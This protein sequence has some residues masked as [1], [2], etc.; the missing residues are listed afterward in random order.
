MESMSNYSSFLIILSGLSWIA[1][2]AEAARV[3]L[4][5]KSYA[6]PV[7]AIGLNLSWAVMHTLLVGQV[8]G[9][10]LPVFIVAVRLELDIVILYTWFKF[11]AK[12]FPSNPGEAWFIPWSLLVI[13]VSFILHSAFILEFG[14]E[15]GLAY[16]AVMQN[17][18]MSMLFIAMLSRRKSKRSQSMIIG[19]AKLTASLSTTIFYG[20][21]EV[22]AS[23]GPNY[24]L[25]VI[26]FL[27]CLFDLIYI[28]LLSQAKPY[29]KKEHSTSVVKRNVTGGEFDAFRV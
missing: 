21:V 4:R 17:L 27:S 28:A 16:T 1:I 24:L 8:D 7:W 23:H 25:L 3:G 22:E 14:T 10:T 6:I 26:G 9:P 13:A 20:I 19:M 5:D 11:G 2:Y 29:E 12:H 18:V 15:H